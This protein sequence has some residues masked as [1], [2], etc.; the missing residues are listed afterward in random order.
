MNKN[1]SAGFIFIFLSL[2]TQPVSAQYYVADNGYSPKY[3]MRSAWVASVGNID[4]P[5]R[6]GLSAEQQ[7]AEY[8]RIVEHAKRTGLNALFVQVRP[9]T[10]AFYPSQYDPWS[11]YITGTQGQ[12]PGY[13]PLLFMIEE[14]HKRGLEFH[15]WLN[16]YRAVVDINR[17]SVSPNHITRRRPEMF[18]TYGKL[19]IF[20]PGLPETRQYFVGVVKDIINRYDVD[21]IHLDDYFYP[22]PEKNDYPDDAAYRKYGNGMSKADWRRENVD[23]IIKEIHDAITQSKPMV[24]FGVSPFGIY[25]NKSQ[26]PIGSDTRGLTNYYTLYADILK[27]LKN[28]WVD[29]IAPQLYWPIGKDG[30]DYRILLKWWSEHTYGKQLYIGQ[31]P[32]NANTS[33]L[34]RNR[35]E[36]PNQIK[37]LRDNPNVHGSVYFSYKSLL[38]NLNGWT[39]S[40]QNN[41][42]K[43]P[44]IV[45]PMAW[46]DRT[47]PMAPEIWS[48]EVNISGNQI[49]ISGAL[50][51]VSTRDKVKSFVLYFTDDFTELGNAPEKIL[52][53]NGNNRFNFALPLYELPAY[54][55]KFYA[56]VTSVDKENNESPLSNII[57]FEKRNGRW[58]AFNGN[59]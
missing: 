49:N 42:Y 3:E 56:V 7:K 26:D 33:A 19:K 48:P 2:F 36:I 20:N 27:W 15:A 35:N 16:P 47:P 38:N 44:A 28:G 21:G 40:L 30:Q 23:L 53:A 24:K 57:R 9:A 12:H 1:F 14:T 10:D 34:W 32:F 4:W 29:Y 6:K 50:N 51:E 39:D 41:Y 22:Y 13:D 46:I 58:T 18:F 25:K 31:G 59:R 45:P 52:V 8:I 43:K 37:L 54:W 17:S 11:E 5:S 55:S